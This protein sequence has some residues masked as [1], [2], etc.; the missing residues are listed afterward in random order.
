MMLPR[1][2]PSAAEI[3]P[4]FSS[5]KP[6]IAPATFEA[7]PEA[8]IVVVGVNTISCGQK[9]SQGTSFAQVLLSGHAQL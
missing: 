7:S 1:A 5:A 6:P 8:D 9:S 2:I 4:G 3:V